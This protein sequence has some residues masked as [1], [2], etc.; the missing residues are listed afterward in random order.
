MC[1][2]LHN[3]F[4][5]ETNKFTHLQLHLDHPKAELHKLKMTLK[6]VITGEDLCAYVQ[7]C[8]MEKSWSSVN[9]NMTLSASGSAVDDISTQS[10]RTFSSATYCSCIGHN[11][12]NFQRYEPNPFES[13]VD[14]ANTCDRWSTL[15]MCENTSTSSDSDFKSSVVMMPGPSDTIQHYHRST[16]LS[17]NNW[18]P[19]Q[20][21]GP[22][23]QHSQ[24]VT[25]ST[26]HRHSG[27]LK[28]FS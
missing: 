5:A 6:S 4:A 28:G 8:V 23:A 11:S 22:S 21:I 17:G 9:L 3:G 25:W 13:A 2:Y 12:I 18:F 20:S 1:K 10:P 16:G 19:T 15:A 27:V 24:H 26:F 7:L 14:A